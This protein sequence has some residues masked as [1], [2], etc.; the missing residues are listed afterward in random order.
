MYLSWKKLIYHGEHG[1]TA[2]FGL[3]GKAVESTLEVER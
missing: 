3:V 1:D 2:G